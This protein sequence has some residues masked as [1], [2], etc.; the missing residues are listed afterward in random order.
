MTIY[1]VGQWGEAS[2]ILTSGPVKLR[3]AMDRAVLQEAQ[4]FRK[5]VVEGFRT[6]RPGGK[7]FRKLSETTLAIRK[8]EGF[9]GSKALIVRGDLRNSVTVVKQNSPI[10]VEA[11]VGV[12]KNAKGKDGKKLVNI[13]EVH[14]KG[15]RPIVIEVTPKMRAYL[16]MAFTAYFGELSG[17]GGGGLSIGIIVTRIP[18]RP[19]IQPVATKWFTG[20]AA[21]TRFLARVAALLGG[22]FGGPLI[23][24][25][26]TRVRKLSL[27]R[28]E[29]GRFISGGEIETL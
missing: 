19:F 26:V 2:R 18:P 10:G 29:K 27:G 7:K 28:D 23:P 6:Q 8:F 25:S 15:S 21:Q 24:S 11:F 14:E 20:A 22:N 12:L 5:K 3:L 4:F 17:G 1:R 9:G 16:A 13:A